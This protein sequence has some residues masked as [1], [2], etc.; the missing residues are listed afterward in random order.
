MRDTL[1]LGIGL[2][3]VSEVPYLSGY[4]LFFGFGLLPF[5]QN[6]MEGGILGLVIELGLQKAWGVGSFGILLCD[7]TDPSRGELQFQ[8]ISSC[9]SFFFSFYVISTLDCQCCVQRGLD[10]RFLPTSEHLSIKNFPC[11]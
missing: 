2:Q 1:I 9:T 10:L 3:G 5:L 11:I 8:E 6:K 4:F 7:P